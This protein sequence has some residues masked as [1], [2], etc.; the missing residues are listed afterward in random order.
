MNCSYLVPWWYFATMDLPRSRWLP[1]PPGLPLCHVSAADLVTVAAG[2]L[3]VFEADMLGEHPEV[4]R[5]SRHVPNS[6][7]NFW[8]ICRAL[9][10]SLL[11]FAW[12]RF[13]GLVSKSWEIAF[14]RP[15]D[16]LMWSKHCDDALCSQ[17]QFL[18][19]W[20]LFDWYLWGSINR[21]PA[22]TRFNCSTT[23]MINR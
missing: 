23:E 20:P 8:V 3:S 6:S 18:W 11:L 13:L 7:T 9:I 14:A 4:V 10:C 16:N 19:N 5:G 12:L 2:L 17:R 15:W 22:F 1:N 21:R